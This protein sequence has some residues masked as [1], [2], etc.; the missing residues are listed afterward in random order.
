MQN[1]TIVGQNTFGGAQVGMLVPLAGPSPGGRRRLQGGGVFNVPSDALLTPNFY[2]FGLDFGAGRSDM[3]AV[4]AAEAQAIPVFLD[5][6]LPLYDFF[7]QSVDIASQQPAGVAAAEGYNAGS[8]QFSS[9]MVP[10]NATD[11][12][13]PAL[14]YRVD[15]N[16]TAGGA[17]SISALWIAVGTDHVSGVFHST[18]A[19]WHESP[20]LAPR[21]VSYPMCA[22]RLCNNKLSTQKSK[23]A[24]I[25]QAAP[26]MAAATRSPSS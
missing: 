22:G 17:R 13:E 8:F 12:I 21:P 23:P 11:V 6:E 26:R 25:P 9:Y 20:T 3:R 7:G 19:R 15:V 5:Q 16:G 2:I 10:A 4:T 14:V 24:A 1:G 18:A